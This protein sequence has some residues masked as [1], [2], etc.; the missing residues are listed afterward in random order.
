MISRKRLLHKQKEIAAHLE[1]MYNKGDLLKN[2]GLYEKDV[3][4]RRKI[5]AGQISTNIESGK[6]GK[7][8]VGHNNYIPGRSYLTVSEDQVQNLVNKYAGSGRMQRD[9]KDRWSHKEII[10][11]D[12]II[13]ISVDPVTG[14]GKETNKFVIHYSKKGVHIV[15]CE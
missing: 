7:H 14:E 2:V 5:K 6:Q 3:S 12:E 11:S 9:G 13:G 10:V 1:S 8:I 4:L 15:P